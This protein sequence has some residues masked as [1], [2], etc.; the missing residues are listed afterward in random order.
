MTGIVVMADYR[1]DPVWAAD[2]SGRPGPMI[3]LDDLPA[4]DKLK[5]DLRAW[6]G[7]YDALAETDY[8][9]PSEDR[10]RRWEASRSTHSPTDWPASWVRCPP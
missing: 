9:W 10:R 5:V 4:S 7:E 8:E 6:A 2:D 3:S 1:A